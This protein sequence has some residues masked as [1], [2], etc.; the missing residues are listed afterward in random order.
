MWIW[1]SLTFRPSN[2]TAI[3][4]PD[5][6]YKTI[7]CSCSFSIFTAARSFVF[8][9]DSTNHLWKL[10]SLVCC[11]QSIHT[12]TALKDSCN[13]GFGY[14]S[15]Q[16]C[17]VMFHI[18]TRQHNFLKPTPLNINLFQLLLVATKQTHRSPF[19]CPSSSILC[20]M[21]STEWLSG[22]SVWCCHQTVTSAE[23]TT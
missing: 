23:G 3:T 21:H 10:H 17:A 20:A 1:R 8:A 6:V 22:C 9:P 4:T 7:T 14:C 15:K 13:K 12:H 5:N 19:S 2:R 18:H 11:L 16:C